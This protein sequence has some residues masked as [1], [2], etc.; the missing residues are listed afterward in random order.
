MIKTWVLDR[1]HCRWVLKWLSPSAWR[2]LPHVS[3][4]VG[5]FACG[6]LGPPP[7]AAHVPPQPPGATVEVP[8]PG[9]GYPPPW[10]W[11][12][13]PGA[14]PAEF[15]PL[16]P[17]LVPEGGPQETFAPGYLAPDVPYLTIA[18]PTQPSDMVPALP[19]S[20]TVTTAPVSEPG[21]LAIVGVGM[22]GVWV[23]RRRA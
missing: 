8:P 6:A 3:A 20:M 23:V 17:V 15:I 18:A 22:L 11:Q 10:Q 14:P 19:G 4:I 16:G 13:P 21:G 9:T 7:P 1:I 2:A 12:P 5:G